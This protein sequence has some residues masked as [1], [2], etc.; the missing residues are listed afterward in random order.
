MHR[1]GVGAHRVVNMERRKRENDACYERSRLVFCKIKSQ[2]IRA[3]PGQYER[4]KEEQVVSGHSAENQLKIGINRRNTEFRSFD[5]LQCSLEKSLIG[6]QIRFVSRYADHLH[7]IR[8]GTRHG[9]EK[10]PGRRPSE[11]HR[12]RGEK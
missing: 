4:D 2:Q 11:N 12:Q 6:D 1:S 8:T 10:M 7:R 5:Q 9:R 3:K